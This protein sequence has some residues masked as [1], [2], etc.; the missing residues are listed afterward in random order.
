MTYYQQ[1]GHIPHKRHTQ[2]RQPDGGLYHEELIGMEGFSGEHSL[3]YHRSLPTEI[4]SVEEWEPVQPAYEPPAP[5]SHRHL[6]SANVPLGGDAISARIPLLGNDDVCISVARPTAPMLYWYRFA[7]GDEVMFVHAG[8]GLLESQFGILHYQVGDYLVIPAGVLWRLIPDRH[9]E[10]KLL[11]IEAYGHIT[12][13]RRYLSEHGQFLEAA[14]YCERDIRSPERL[15]TY[16][17]T[18]RCEIHVKTREGV[19][20]Y[21]ATHTPLDVVGWAGHLWP[22]ALNIHDFE[23][24][25]GRIH[26][27]PSVHQTFTGPNCVVCSFVPRLFD[28]H[29]ESIPAPYNHSNVDSTEVIYY[30]DGQF[31]SR[32]GI[33]PGSLTVHPSGLAHG[34]QPGLY[35]ASIGKSHTEELAVMVDTFSPLRLTTHATALEAE[36]Y[37]YSWQSPQS[38]AQNQS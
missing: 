1:L 38:K 26:Q 31:M 7:Q 12:P 8:G 28:Y 17:D 34:P 22:Y 35:E 5:L 18:G 14:P 9:V 25:T 11:V 13:P 24:I 23:P 16:P 19:T 36:G 3:L 15:V 20:R 33:E 30:V 21:F 37:I 2:F 29:P 10:Q 6:K 27:P 4:A 32:K